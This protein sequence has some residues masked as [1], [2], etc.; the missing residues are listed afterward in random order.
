S[1]MAW[2][3]AASL[4]QVIATRSGA[5]AELPF[6]TSVGERVHALRQINVAELDFAVSAE[7]VLVFQQAEGEESR[8]SDLECEEVVFE[9]KHFAGNSREL[10]LRRRNN[11]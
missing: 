6:L 8:T 9:G 3:I 1:V 11:H 7:H 5:L 10:V 4:F 2:L